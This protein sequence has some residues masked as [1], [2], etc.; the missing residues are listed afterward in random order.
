MARP[1]IACVD[2]ELLNPGDEFTIEFTCTGK[3]SIPKVEARIEGINQIALL[4]PAHI[5]RRLA[6]AFV[7]VV[8][9]FPIVMITLVLILQPPHSLVGL[10][11]M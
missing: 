5:E 7:Y 1:N 11:V 4:E 9:G 2:F 8:T 10:L 6:K 3:S